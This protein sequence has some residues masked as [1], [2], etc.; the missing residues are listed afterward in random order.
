MNTRF[1]SF[2]IFGIGVCLVYLNGCSNVKDLP[3]DVK[4]DLPDSIIKVFDRAFPTAEDAVFKKL[5][6]EKEKFYEVN[7]HVGQDKFYSVLNTSTILKSF[8][9]LNEPPDSLRKKVAELPPPG[10]VMTDFRIP[11][12]ASQ[13][14]LMVSRYKLDGKDYTVSWRWAAGASVRLDMAFQF[15]LHY[16]LNAGEVNRLPDWI[17]A[18]LQQNN[19]TFYQAWVYVKDDNTA[20]YDFHAQGGNSLYFFSFDTDGTLEYTTF[21]VATNYRSLAE[22]PVE[23][24]N[25]V[26]NSPVLST[27]GFFS[28]ASKYERDG[29]TAYSLDM[30]IQPSR[31]ADLT[32]FYRII[33]DQNGGFKWFFCLAFNP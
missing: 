31:E 14:T 18:Y 22:M 29:K 27:R 12:Y 10:G 4:N 3:P 16:Q 23:I 33:F 17:L 5:E 21:P 11:S 8:R 15:K 13:D 1:T 28:T 20:R 6:F 32:G 25:Y 7:F 19:L 24:Q 9:L 30:A 26:K 2:L